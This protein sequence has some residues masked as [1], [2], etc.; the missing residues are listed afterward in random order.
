MNKIKKHKNMFLLALALVMAYAGY[1]A[2]EYYIA[3]ADLPVLGQTTT[4][5]NGN[6]VYHSIADFEVVNQM[7]D[8]LRNDDFK[9]KIHVANFFFTSCP[10]ICPTITQ[11]LRTVQN[12][13][14]LEE[15][16]FVSFS[17]D[18]K[19]DSVPRLKQFA[20]RMRV[21]EANWHFVVADKSSIYLLARNSYFLVAVEGTAERNDFI[22]SE[23]VALVD[24]DM[25][26]R[27]FYDGMDEQE[28][29]KLESDILKLHRSY[30]EHD[31]ADQFN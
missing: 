19:R 1:H 6:R 7:G 8:T 3:M 23:Q 20:E 17:I 25:R 31:L 2:R 29:V 27:G 24:K 22:H 12:N 5:E 28:M 18:P 4:D 14:S 9:G 21:D 15:L 11:N 10:L 13:L 30:E 16:V 26:I